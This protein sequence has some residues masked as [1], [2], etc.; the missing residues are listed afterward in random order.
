VK[1]QQ[2]GG[3]ARQAA[4]DL[5]ATDHDDRGQY[6]LDRVSARVSP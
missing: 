4:I 3:I 2:I 5:L 6:F 1:P